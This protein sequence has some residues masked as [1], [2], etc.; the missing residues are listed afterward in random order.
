VLDTPAEAAFDR[1]TTLVS[2]LLD[3]PV[4]LVS[5]VAT[6]RQFFK[7]CVGQ[8]AEPWMSA[9]QTP[10]S[11]SFCQHVVELAEPLV[12]ED[13][14]EHPLVR[15]NLAIPDL[16]VVA[17]AGVPITTPE[18]EI[19]GSLCAIDTSPREWSEEHLSSLSLL[20]G[21]VNTEVALRLEVRRQ[22]EMLAELEVAKEK[23][24]SANRARTA[25]LASV[26]HELRTP[27]SAII[28]YAELLDEPS[29]AEEQREFSAA[30][31]GAASE[32]LGM[33]EGILDEVQAA[34][35]QGVAKDIAG[36]NPG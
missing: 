4:A 8:I 15:D 24:E 9:R 19:L 2:R 20:V 34:S 32:L 6:D 1:V 5:F 27:L 35:E 14:R 3:V 25:F 10:L 22:R 31:R 26:S 28:G 17:Y 21:S 13:A 7:S 11:H 33:V 23:A 30:V 12:I 29:S 18:G 16:G 36:S